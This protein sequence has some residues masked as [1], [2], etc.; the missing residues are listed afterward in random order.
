MPFGAFLRFFGRLFDLFFFFLV[1][2]DQGAVIVF[3]GSRRKGAK[4][5]IRAGGDFFL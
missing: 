3:R 1:T 5:L 2:G 4:D